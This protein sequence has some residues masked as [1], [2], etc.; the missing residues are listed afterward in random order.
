MAK[1]GRKPKPTAVRKNMGNPGKRALPKNEPNPDRPARMPFAPSYLTEVGKKE[2]RRM[3][4]KL[5]KAGLLTEIDLTAFAAYC[6]HYENWVDATGQV[7]KHGMLI[8]AQSGFPMLSPYYTIQSKESA[9][10]LKCLTEFGMSPS[11]RSRVEVKPK[12]KE[13]D[14]LDKFFDGPSLVKK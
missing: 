13:V 11:S 10:M 2:W 5:F 4:K 14:P 9:A 6:Q 7:R 8:K 3:G 1:P 12:E